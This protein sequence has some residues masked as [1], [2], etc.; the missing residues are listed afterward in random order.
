MPMYWQSCLSF[1]G[2]EK[3]NALIEGEMYTSSPHLATWLETRHSF[4]HP[5]THSLI[6]S[7]IL[8]CRWHRL[9]SWSQMRRSPRRRWR[10]RAGRPT[11][12]WQTACTRCCPTAPSCSSPCQTWTPCQLANAP[13][14][15]QPPPRLS[16]V[17]RCAA[18]Q[19]NF[20][21]NVMSYSVT[22]S[23]KSSYNTR[24]LWILP[25]RI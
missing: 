1:E 22:C 18:A 20:C 2:V 5:F 24:K 23:V 16:G 13:S 15:L 9:T 3:S 8:R 7:L 10:Q 25:V 12:G 4:I 11:C 14:P 21:D 17:Q 6:H 19:P